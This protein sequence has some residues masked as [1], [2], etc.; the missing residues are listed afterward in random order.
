MD[1]FP[2][3]LVRVVDPLSQKDPLQILPN[4]DFINDP[5][6]RIRK[7]TVRELLPNRTFRTMELLEALPV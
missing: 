5:A 7:K 3:A 1:S 6:I 2:N 4:Y